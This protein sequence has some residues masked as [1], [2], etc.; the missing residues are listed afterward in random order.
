MKIQLALR[1]FTPKDKKTLAAVS[2]SFRSNDGFDTK[3]VITELAMGEAL[4]STL[5]VNGSPTPVERLCVHP[6]CVLAPQLLM[7]ETP[8][9]R[10]HLPA[11]NTPQ[12]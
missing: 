4:V 12:Q 2:N 5:S 1:A 8:K 7:K 9:W 10:A 11:V 6:C 3:K